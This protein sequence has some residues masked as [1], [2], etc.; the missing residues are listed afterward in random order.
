M[1][2]D[3]PPHVWRR[4]LLPLVAATILAASGLTFLLMIQFRSYGEDRIAFVNQNRVSIQVAVQV[5]AA[6]LSG[7][8]F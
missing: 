8:Q 6:A 3:K 4:F 1:A 5:T 7:L 2:P